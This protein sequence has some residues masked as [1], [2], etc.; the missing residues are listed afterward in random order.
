MFLVPS[1]VAA[2]PLPGDL[3]GDGVIS[4]SDETL[5]RGYYGSPLGSPGYEP[6][7]DLDG[8]GQ[9]GVQDLA[10][11]GAAYGD[12]GG[13]VDETPPGLFVTL[14]DIP[15]DMND[16]LVAPPGGFQITLAIDSAGGSAID[17]SSLT[18]SSS[19][20]MGAL[21]AGA[22][23]A[24]LFS[25]T[26]QRAVWDVPPGT[27]LARTTHTL[28]VSVR[29]HAGNQA[30]AAY[31]YAVRDFASA[32]PLANEQKIYLDFT[33][34]R[35]LTPAIDFL[36]D[37]RAFG[38]SS[39]SAPDLEATVRALVVAEILARVHPFYGRN[40]DGSPGPDAANV[41]FFDLAPAFPY[42]RLCVG[43]QSSSGPLYLGAT[44]I[45]PG[46]SIEAEDQC[47]YPGPLYGVFPQAIDDLWGW[48]AGFQALFNPL[49]PGL[50]IPVGS[51]PLD[52]VV[53]DP[54]F[55][56]A[57]ASAAEL[58]RLSL[59]QAATSSFAQIVATAIA[60]E[61]AHMLGLVAGGPTPG[62]LFGGPNGTAAQDHNLT[63]L[64]ATPG[65][66]YLM[67][68]GGSFSFE[69]ITGTGGIPL[70]VFRPL[71][72][73]YLRDRIVLNGNVWGLFPAPTLSSVA[74]SWVDPEPSAL[75][76]ITGT[77][78]LPK[79]NG[80]PPAVHLIV[81]GDPTPNAVIGVVLVN[82]QTITGTVSKYLAPPALYDVRVTNGDD[83]VVT[84]ID[85]LVVQ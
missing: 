23:L 5:L 40:P 62:G 80:A 41:R 45:D 32:P 10:R 37:L 11:F 59:I 17:P 76:T 51:D 2:A 57:T 7:A 50:G 73:A 34:N 28:S 49:K 3:D 16:L 42:S 63:P 79:P 53:L 52:A 56:P 58:A 25:V 31:G 84:A 64:G 61:T 46:N 68:A 4:S 82:P 22:P 29:D 9:I 21:P 44:S 47:I 1:L 19:Q 35:S 6:A 36:E 27:G 72:W 70:P 14:N 65:E 24:P 48:T 77:G 83:Q 85:A 78:F 8:D 13:D 69:E 54:A 67:N 81:E 39:A 20:P 60:H 66:N 26:P 55:D 38:L 74:P 71:N 30:N 12:S 75:L 33:R 18:V 15:D 43:G